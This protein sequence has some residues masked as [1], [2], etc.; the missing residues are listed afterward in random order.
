MFACGAPRKC[1][2]SSLRVTAAAIEMR[3]V[4]T[5]LSAES[6]T[7]NLSFRAGIATGTVVG[8]ILGSFCVLLC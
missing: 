8:G 6:N 3:R 4:L 5:Q 1:A 7:N 2:D